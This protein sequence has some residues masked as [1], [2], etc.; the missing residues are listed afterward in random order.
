MVDKHIGYPGTVNSAELAK[1][2]PNVASCQ[3][4]VEGP[5]D[6][7]VVTSDVGVRGL[8]IRSGTV[9]GDGIMDIFEADTPMNLAAV[10][11]GSRWDMIVLRRTWSATVGTSTSIYTAIQGNANK[12]LPARNNNK[13]V[14]SDQPIALCRV[15]AGKNAV[16]EIIDLRCWA[17]NGG[18][19]AKSDLVRSYLYEPGTHLTIEGVSW[20]RRVA[21]GLTADGEVWLQ[22]GSVSA[23]NLFANGIGI[24]GNAGGNMFFTQAGSQVTKSDA[25]GYARITFPK[26]FPNGLLFVGGFNGDDWAT[27]GGGIHFASAGT[28]ANNTFGQ[29]GLGS[30]TEWVY[31]TLGQSPST[32]IVGRKANL[33]HR[34]NWIAIGW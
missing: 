4:S 19:Y 25:Q 6:A 30:K 14:I 7:K 5:S 15:D 23:M 24:L 26:P 9:I 18:V 28:G 29:A 16:Q 10:T 20:V 34:I 17:H 2:M 12:T 11:T 32:L 13:G 21:N 1:W 27:G 31:A 8:I 22:V 3:Y 33:L